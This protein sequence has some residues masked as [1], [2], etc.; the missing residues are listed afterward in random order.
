MPRRSTENVCEL[1]EWNELHQPWLKPTASCAAWLTNVSK[2]RRPRRS[3]A[4]LQERGQE[5]PTLRIH[6]IND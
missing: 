1:G 3:D 5:L 4:L 6:T 2:G